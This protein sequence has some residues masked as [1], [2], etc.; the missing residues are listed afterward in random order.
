MFV[1]E[2]DR[3][4]QSQ[5]VRVSDAAGVA[6]VRRLVVA[7]TGRADG[8]GRG[9]ERYPQMAS[10]TSSSLKIAPNLFTSPR[11]PKWRRFIKLGLRFDFQL[12]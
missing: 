4:D 8:G 9:S 10:V 11:T 5:E 7:A 1:A 6:Y 12:N 3:G 2:T